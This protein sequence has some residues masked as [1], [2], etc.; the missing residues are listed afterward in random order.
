VVRSAGTIETTPE[1]LELFAR[2]LGRDHRVALE[3]TA[4]GASARRGAKTDRLDARPLPGL[5]WAGEL[6][7]R[8]YRPLE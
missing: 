6:D 2:T 7:E 4:V 3:V 5:L 1:R 8:P